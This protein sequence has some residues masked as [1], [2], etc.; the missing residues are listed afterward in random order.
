MVKVDIQEI[1]CNQ[2]FQHRLIYQYN[3]DCFDF[4]LPVFAFLF[5]LHWLVSAVVYM[6]YV[7]YVVY[8]AKMEYM[9]FFPLPFLRYHLPQLLLAMVY[10]IVFHGEESWGLDL[11][12]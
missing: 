9:G 2:T 10:D 4:F 6:A 5:V 11:V 3:H 8:L 7:G 12:M 1:Y